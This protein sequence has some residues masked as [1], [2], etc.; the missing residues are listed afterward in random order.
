L[1]PV[2]HLQLG[3]ED[4]SL[5]S[6]TR[7]WEGN[8]YITSFSSLWKLTANLELIF[9]LSFTEYLQRNRSLRQHAE[10]NEKRLL[11]FDVEYKDGMLF[12]MERGR[13]NEVFVFNV[14]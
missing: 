11:L 3:R 8:F 12:L 4:I 1:D 13:F 10:R 9:Q 6:I 5:C 14:A 7:D 2:K